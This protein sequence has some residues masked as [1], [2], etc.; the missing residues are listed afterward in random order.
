MPDLAFIGHLG[1][2]AAYQAV[3][4]AARGPDLPAPRL[5]DV[6]RLLPYLEPMP[7]SDAV[8]RT[9]GGREV[10]GRYFDLFFLVEETLRVKSGLNRV[11]AACAQ[12]KSAGVRIGALGGFSSILGEMARV[13]VSK[14]LGVPFTTGNTLTAATV[15]AQVDTAAPRHAVVTVVGAAGDVGTGVCR[16][17]ARAGRR[18]VLVGRNPAPLDRLC[19]ELP[20]A[21]S[22]RWEEAA[23]EVEVAVLL[24]SAAGG[25]IPLDR[26]PAGAIVLDGG[27][28]ANAC[29]ASHIRYAQAGRVMVDLVVDLPAVLEQ[30]CSPGELPACLAEAVVLALE[31]RYE[32]YSSGR[33][34]IEPDRA[35]AILTMAARH[36]ITPAPLRLSTPGR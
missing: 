22:R 2:P 7:L 28:P 15:A 34:L 27:H 18:L 33:G 25:S 12:A 32:P 5:E 30:H 29:P 23:P 24:A 26:L 36:G 10:H 14:E 13:D 21:R 1:S 6:Q 31:E 16:L 3:L 20:T 9:P 17:L 19:R 11:R 8:I 4:A 35:V